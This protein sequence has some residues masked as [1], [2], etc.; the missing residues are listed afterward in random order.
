M[1]CRCRF[2]GAWAAELLQ[3]DGVNPPMCPFAGI[4]PLNPISPQCKGPMDIEFLRRPDTNLYLRQVDTT[5]ELN[6]RFAM[7]FDKLVRL[8]PELATDAN[9]TT[10]DVP[11]E[12]RKLRIKEWANITG[13]WEFNP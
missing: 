10:I 7:A 3:W 8:L 4:F 2:D 12:Q 11:W 1:F 5:T 13:K 6:F 9:V